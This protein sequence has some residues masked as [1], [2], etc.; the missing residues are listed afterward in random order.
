MGELIHNSQ[1]IKELED[2]GIKTLEEL[3][4]NG[5]GICVIRSHGASLSLIEEI[6]KQGFEVVDLTCPDVK[7][8]QNKAIELVLEG[9]YLI[10][11][12]SPKHPEV[13]AIEANARTFAKKADDVFVV[14]NLDVLKNNLENIK[15]HKKIGIVIQT[16][17]KIEYLKEIVDYLLPYSKDL[18]VINTI[19]LS[20]TL[21]QNEAREIAKNSDLMV[22]IG[23]R[24]SANTTHLANILS[25]ITDTIH[26]EDDMELES[27][28]DKISGAKKIGITAGASTPDYI[29][30]KV[31]DKLKGA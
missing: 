24:K 3:P 17:Q 4:K 2:L 26:I 28:K 9:Y 1:V 23:S 10:I 27:F 21:R 20:T 14:S 18:K 11:L 15:N 8:V 30:K 22:V 5:E 29:I 12:G 31:I 7:K 19:C 25:N 16:T 6:K 13:M